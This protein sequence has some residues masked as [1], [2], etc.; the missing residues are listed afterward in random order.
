MTR[1]LFWY[2][3]RVRPIRVSRI[4]RNKMG[5]LI[6]VRNYCCCGGGGF[7]WGFP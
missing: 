1:P 2:I 4:L 5:I 6:F 3:E 7:G